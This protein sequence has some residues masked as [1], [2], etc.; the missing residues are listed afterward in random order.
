M[1]NLP[2]STNPNT[3]KAKSGSRLS[4]NIAGFGPVAFASSYTLNVDNT[5]TDIDVLDQL[6]VAEFAETA[7]KVTGSV[8]RFKIDDDAANFLNIDPSDLNALFSR[9]DLS[10]DILDRVTGNSVSSL[11]GVKFSGG[12]GTVDARGVWTGTWNFKARQTS[13][14]SNI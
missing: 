1:A 10:I 9:G 6:E 3:T 2:S 12:T 5:L 8:N 11:T 13:E 4:I 14:G 7:H